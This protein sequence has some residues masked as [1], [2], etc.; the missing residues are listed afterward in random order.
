MRCNPSCL[1]IALTHIVFLPH[2]PKKLP[3]YYK[4]KSWHPTSSSSSPISG[5]QATASRHGASADDP[6]A[7]A[8]ASNAF[9]LDQV[10]AFPIS[11]RNMALSLPQDSTALPSIACK[12]THVESERTSGSSSKPT[13][14]KGK[15]KRPVKGSA[16]AARSAKEAAESS[17]SPSSASAQS[18]SNGTYHSVGQQPAEMPPPA[19]PLRRSSSTTST[20]SA[21][22]ISLVNT[23]IE[24]VFGRK[25][26]FDQSINQAN[27]ATSPP[28]AM[29]A[30]LA[31]TSAKG[32]ARY[33]CLL[34]RC[35]TWVPAK[36]G[37]VHKY[38]THSSFDTMD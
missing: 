12:P 26:S 3:D 20:S 22:P 31:Q 7:R 24:G 27:Q 1:Q 16:R 6:L 23:S 11:W 18:T 28:T 30:R 37:L 9:T 5:T 10:L 19:P 32:C 36:L 2:S 34:S 38:R 33:P 25:L 13:S 29:H 14:S 15:G 21:L 35:P 8:L 17:G 4:I